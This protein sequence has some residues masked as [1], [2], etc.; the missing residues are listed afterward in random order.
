MQERKESKITKI[1]LISEYPGVFE[2]P[3]ILNLHDITRDS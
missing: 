1:F 3:T 2:V